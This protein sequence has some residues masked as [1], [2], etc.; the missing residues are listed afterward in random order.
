MSLEIQKQKFQSQLTVHDQSV[1]LFSDKERC[2]SQS[3][4]ALYEN[5]T[6]MLFDTIVFHDTCKFTVAEYQKKNKG[7]LP[8]LGHSRYQTVYT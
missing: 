5:F 7:I 6:I 4:R 8:S 3:E 1:H 2:F